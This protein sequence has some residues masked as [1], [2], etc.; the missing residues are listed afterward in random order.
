MASRIEKIVKSK[1]KLCLYGV[2]LTMSW[3][4]Y[5]LK[6]ESFF[7]YAMI[8]DDNEQVKNKFLPH[9]TKYNRICDFDS[10]IG[11]KISNF[12]LTVNPFYHFKMIK[13]I[14]KY[15]SSAN[16][17]YINKQDLNLIK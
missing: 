11:S 7:K 6:L 16:I 2:G 17:Y 5:E 15:F 8:V 9:T 3:L 12:F 10:I 4:L 13:R 14:K 1:K